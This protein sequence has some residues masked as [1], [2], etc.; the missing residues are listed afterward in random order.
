LIP[1]T[2][3]KHRHANLP[4]WVVCPIKEWWLANTT[5]PVASMD[6][7]PFREGKSLMAPIPNEGL[8]RQSEGN[9]REPLQILDL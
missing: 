5:F 3:K 6:F 1:N 9:K 7:E 2:L 4:V 8:V